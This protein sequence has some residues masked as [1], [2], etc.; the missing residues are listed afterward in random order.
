M[1][2]TV[3]LYE[4]RSNEF[5]QFGNNVVSICDESD[6]QVLKIQEPLDKLRASLTDLEEIYKINQASAITSR[7]TELDDR[8]D[9]AVI[10]LRKLGD[11]FTNHFDEAKQNAGKKLVEVIDRY[12]TPIYKQ[13]YQAETG[14]LNNLINDLETSSEYRE[15]LDLL[16]GTEVLSEMKKANELFDQKYLLR[17][18]QE[19][20]KDDESFT[21]KR[22]EAK[23]NYRDL[24]QHIE[25][26]ATVT[27]T[28]GY[29]HLINRFNDLIDRYNQLVKLRSSKETSEEDTLEV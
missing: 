2:N 28:D 29:T 26:W 11:T 22:L 20:G 7:L 5:I 23:N 8:R 14:S 1:I 12:G 27:P 25:A 16:G 19:A 6:P 15:I 9:N 13:N 3:L 10:F 24:V 18:D 21:E 4:F 17:N